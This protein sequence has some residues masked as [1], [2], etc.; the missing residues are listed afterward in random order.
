MEN[1]LPINNYSVKILIFLIFLLINKSLNGQYIINGVVSDSTLKKLEFVNVILITNSTNKFIDYDITDDKGRFEIKTNLP[2]DSLI[3]SF[4]HVLYR[5]ENYK[6]SEIDSTDNISIIL[7]PDQFVLEEIEIK[8][9]TNFIRKSDTISYNLDYYRDSTEQNIGELLQKIPGIKVDPNGNI[10]VYSKPINALTIDGINI[11]KNKYQVISSSLRADIVEKAEIIFNYE[12]NDLIRSFFT[13]SDALSINLVTKEKFKHS[14]TGNL[15]IGLSFKNYELISNVFILGNKLKVINASD[16]NNIGRGSQKLIS[17]KNNII[18]NNNINAVFAPLW[19]NKYTNYERD[20][21]RIN[22]L[23]K[24]RVD[25][26][27]LPSLNNTKIHLNAEGNLENFS[28]SSSIQYYNYNIGLYRTDENNLKNKIRDFYIGLIATTN[29]KKNQQINVQLNFNLS[30]AFKENLINKTTWDTKNRLIDGNVKLQYLNK[31]SSKI[32]SISEFEYAENHN[33]LDLSFVFLPFEHA[34]YN[35]S[36]PYKNNLYAFITSKKLNQV[37]FI[38]SSKNIFGLRF[39]AENYSFKAD[40]ILGDTLDYLSNIRLNLQE[41]YKYSKKGELVGNIEAGIFRSKLL[42]SIYEANQ[43][44]RPYLNYNLSLKQSINDHIDGQL[45]LYKKN[46]IESFHFSKMPFWIMPF[47]LMDNKYPFRLYN[48]FS[49]GQL[50]NYRSNYP[51]LNISNNFSYNL[52]NFDF[53]GADTV[54][55][56]SIITQMILNPNRQF[57]FINSS[58]FD[59][60]IEPLNTAFKS[61]ISYSQGKLPFI[62]NGIMTNSKSKSW[63]TVISL[64]TAFIFPINFDIGIEYYHFNTENTMNLLTES[65]NTLY[66]KKSFELIFKFLGMSLNWKNY[67]FQTKNYA[68][69]NLNSNFIS[70]LD[71]SFNIKKSTVEV[72]AYNLF[73]KEHLNYIN[74]INTGEIVSQTLINPRILLIKYKIKF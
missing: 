74:Q 47:I 68:A 40:N 70:D 28:Q 22:D 65:N 2:K 11:T 44:N 17:L 72:I 60:F 13:E 50:F 37:F 25:A 54:I 27:F 1:I 73:E 33:N 18:S 19:S 56:S 15:D 42:N 62:T 24:T 64:R 9:Q 63:N 67:L 20:L 39:D 8:E 48:S 43:L 14:T 66:Q 6:L 46:N 32:M 57:Q 58:S 61:S 16:I 7:I 35:F 52:T 26:V 5:K 71:L 12:E 31:I 34:N 59:F 23:F 29:I 30:A 69:E 45:Y 49:I 10:S 53:I 41:K 38:K 4:S 21:I 36:S 51:S 3:L 55:E